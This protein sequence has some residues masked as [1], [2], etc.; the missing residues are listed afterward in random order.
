ML[1][2][3]FGRLQVEEVR[4]CTLELG[5]WPLLRS[6]GAGAAALQGAAAR[7]VAVRAWSLGVPLMAGCACGA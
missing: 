7:C 6:L 4:V 3:L 1:V 2:Y 5:C